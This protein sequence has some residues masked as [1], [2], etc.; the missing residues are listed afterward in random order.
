MQNHMHGIPNA[1]DT[2]II[3]LVEQIQYSRKMQT[4]T[5]IQ[6]EIDCTIL[7]KL[8]GRVHACITMTH[9]CLRCFVI[10]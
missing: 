10:Q 6:A 7:N 3:I 2:A 5:Q 8:F 9:E 1:L 4:Q